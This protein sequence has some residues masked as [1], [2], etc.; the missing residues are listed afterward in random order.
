MPVNKCLNGTQYKAA[1]FVIFAVFNECLQ[2]F[3]L[4]TL[5][6]NFSLNFQTERPLI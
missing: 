4:L 5:K 6:P 3:L 1:L 2:C